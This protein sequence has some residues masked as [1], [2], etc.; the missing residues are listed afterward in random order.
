[1]PTLLR[2]LRLRRR[3]KGDEG[4]RGVRLLCVVAVVVP[5][6]S[7]PSCF[8]CYPH[9][10][11]PPRCVCCCIAR[12]VDCCIVEFRSFPR[13]T[14]ALLPLFCCVVGRSSAKSLAS[15]SSSERLIVM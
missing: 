8:P 13:A 10:P 9:L 1:M 12:R 14:S 6:S 3:G 11:A 15:S 5:I 2:L 7:F 4:P